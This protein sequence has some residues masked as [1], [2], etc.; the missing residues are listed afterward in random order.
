MAIS[1]PKHRKQKRAEGDIAF[2]EL[3]RQRSYLGEYDSPE[4]RQQYHHLL[5]ESWTL[6]LLF[7]AKSNTAGYFG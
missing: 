4:S 3:K 2:V 5:S 7:I 1:T 6:K